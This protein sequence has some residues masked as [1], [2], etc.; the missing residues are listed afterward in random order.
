MELIENKVSE[1]TQKENPLKNF[2]INNTTTKKQKKVVREDKNK[3]FVIPRNNRKEKNESFVEQNKKEE[4][5]KNTKNNA[6]KKRGRPKKD[7]SDTKNVKK[8]KGYASSKNESTLSDRNKTSSTSRFISEKFQYELEEP[9]KVDPEVYKNWDFKKGFP[10][11][12]RYPNHLKNVLHQY[13]RAVI[14]NPNSKLPNKKKQ[15]QFIR[16]DDQM[17]VDEESLVEFHSKMYNPTFLN[18]IT[19]RHLAGK[20]RGEKILCNFS[21]IEAVLNIAKEFQIK[22]RVKRVVKDF[23]GQERVEEVEVDVYESYQQTESLYKK[24]RFDCFPRQPKIIVQYE[25][26]NKQVY[27]MLLEEDRTLIEEDTNGYIFWNKRFNVGLNVVE[28]RYMIYLITSAA[29]LSFWLW[30]IRNGILDW[31]EQPQNFEFIKEQMERYRIKEKQPGVKKRKE[32]VTKKQQTS[33]F[34]SYSE[35]YVLN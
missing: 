35:K 1:E 8:L 26:V 30:A 5:E 16:L 10:T 7:E 2:F 12:Y 21:H 34:S 11:R 24:T 14:N 6:K 9:V 27:D 31:C 29:Q 25:D 19:L 15:K 28:G 3:L 22:T 13:D 4:P 33:L 32:I 23:D 17:T 20:L 18:Q